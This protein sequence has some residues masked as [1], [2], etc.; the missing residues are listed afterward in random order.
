MTLIVATLSLSV[1]CLEGWGHSGCEYVMAK[2]HFG[3]STD[4]LLENMVQAISFESIS[5]YFPAQMLK[6]NLMFIW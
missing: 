2:S 3:K 4:R 6:N 1:I 5:Q